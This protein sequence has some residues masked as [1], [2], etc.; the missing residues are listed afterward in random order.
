MEQILN[1]GRNPTLYGRRVV[2]ANA[3]TAKLNSLDDE[4]VEALFDVPSAQQLRNLAADISNRTRYLDADAMSNSGSPNILGQLRAAAAADDQI[5]REYRD[6]AIAPFLRGENGAASKM[7]P[8]ELVP[9]LYRKAAP[10]ETRP[11]LDKL[12]APMRPRL[13][14]ASSPTSSRAP[15][16][17]GAAI[18]ATSGALSPARRTRRTARV[19]PRCSERAGMPQVASNPSASRR[20]CRRKAGRRCAISR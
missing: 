8:E 6:G 10:H 1:T 18:L 3:L 17:K 2:D 19:L 20:C 5:A 7:R 16:R 15:S 14:A 11:V 12:S 13:S 4:T 9:W